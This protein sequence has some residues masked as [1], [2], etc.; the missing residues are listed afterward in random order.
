MD[1]PITDVKPATSE[2]QK[3]V[4]DDEYSEYSYDEDEKEK[5]FL[6]RKDGDN[7]NIFSSLLKSSKM[8]LNELSTAGIKT[9]G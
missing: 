2:V 5:T 3:D 6:Q 7:E 9:D 8:L 4:E 1:L